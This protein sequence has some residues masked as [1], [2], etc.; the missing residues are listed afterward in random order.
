MHDLRLA[1][2]ALVRDRGTSA[3]AILALGLALGVNTGLFSALHA[4]LLRE[5]PFSGAARVGRLLEGS[6]S[7]GGTSPAF[8]GGELADLPGALHA[9]SEVAGYRSHAFNGGPAGSPVRFPR[10]VAPTRFFRVFP[11]RVLAGR[12]FDPEVPVGTREAVLSERLWRKMFASDPGVV[13]RTLM[14]NGEAVPVVGIV[15]AEFAVPPETGVCM[16]PAYA[17][18]HHPLRAP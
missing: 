18:P 4:V 9:F 2:R 6:F 12:T 17:V 16:T 3:L 7:G 11:A 10:A 5:L 1:A 13:G 8:S 14:L 15:A